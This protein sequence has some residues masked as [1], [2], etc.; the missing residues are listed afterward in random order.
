M[1]IFLLILFLFIITAC[2][3]PIYQYKKAFKEG[4]I[5]QCQEDTACIDLIKKEFDG[6]IET[7]EDDIQHLLTA[8]SDEKMTHIN[9]KI[10]QN[11]WDCLL[12]KIL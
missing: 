4:L 6:C 2:N 3:D 9:N 7:S 10:R 8:Q 5:V 12:K 11:T 1:K